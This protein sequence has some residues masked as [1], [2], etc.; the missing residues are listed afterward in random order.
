[1]TAHQRGR[2]TGEAVVTVSQPIFNDD[3]WIG[4]I[5]ISIPRVRLQLPARTTGTIAPIE[6][7]TFNVAGDDDPIGGDAAAGAEGRPF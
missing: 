3:E 5:I 4:H 1:M 7:V 6:V 2:F